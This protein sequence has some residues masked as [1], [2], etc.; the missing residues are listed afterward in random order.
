MF[1]YIFML[2]QPG[3]FCSSFC[4]SFLSGRAK[5]TGIA[6]ECSCCIL[7]TETLL[8]AIM[9]LRTVCKEKNRQDEPVLSFSEYQNRHKNHPISFFNVITGKTF[10]PIG[11][12]PRYF[13]EDLL[14][15]Y[16]KGLSFEAWLD[17]D[18]LLCAVSYRYLV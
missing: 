10:N 17:Q 3:T 11:V 18:M 12:K 14:K 5:T 6:E 9:Y 1:C 13:P 2:H 4:S 7:H 16:I 8:H 15:S